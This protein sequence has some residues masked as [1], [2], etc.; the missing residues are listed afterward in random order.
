MG[1]TWAAG[2]APIGAITGWIAAS[3]LGLRVGTVAGNIAMLF[4]ALGLVGGAIFSTVVSIAER[5]RTLGELTLPRFLAWGAL[6]GFALGGIA[7]GAGLFFVAPVGLSLTIVGAS[8]LLGVAS[9]AGTLAIARAPG[10]RAVSA[11]EEQV[12]FLE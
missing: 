4:G 7:V 8:T 9:A 10:S 5:S 1:L 3:V 6:G 12:A 11:G 2:W